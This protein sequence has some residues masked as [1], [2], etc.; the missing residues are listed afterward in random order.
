[1]SYL[2][3]NILG[4]IQNLDKSRIVF[5]RRKMSLFHTIRCRLMGGTIL[6]M[7]PQMHRLI[8]F[9][10]SWLVVWWMGEN[11]TP[12][13]IT[14]C[15]NE[16]VNCFGLDGIHVKYSPRGVTNKGQILG[17][18]SGIISGLALDSL[19][20]F[21]GFALIYL[22]HCCYFAFVTMIEWLANERTSRTKYGL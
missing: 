2:F 3:G 19:P 13:Y 4:V 10:L 7:S 15:V 17:S 5:W 11:H 9:L 12:F 21:S 6:W 16:C 18:N 1:M 22:E 14:C 8:R 20:E